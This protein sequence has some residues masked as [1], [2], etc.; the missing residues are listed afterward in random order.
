[1]ITGAYRASEAGK[2]VYNSYIDCIDTEE[3]GHG[4]VTNQLS[5]LIKNHSCVKYCWKSPTSGPIFTGDLWT[6]FLETLTKGN[7]LPSVSVNLCPWIPAG[8]WI[9]NCFLGLKKLKKLP[10]DP[11]VAHQNTEQLSMSEG[12]PPVKCLPNWRRDPPHLVLASA[13][14]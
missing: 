9:P 2:G 7:S 11:W 10:S 13:R 4:Y 5:V 8:F 6:D 14:V 3:A 1:M 12:H